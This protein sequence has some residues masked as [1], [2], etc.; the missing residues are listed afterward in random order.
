MLRNDLGL[1][2]LNIYRPDRYRRYMP[3]EQFPDTAPGQAIDNFVMA[4]VNHYRRVAMSPQCAYDS[5]GQIF[6]LKTNM[7]FDIFFRHAGIL[8]QSG[9]CGKHLVGCLYIALVAHISAPEFMFRP[10][11]FGCGCPA[12]MFP[13]GGR[14]AAHQCDIT[15]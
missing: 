1:P 12:A 2:V 5:F 6:T 8:K 14:T 10:G 15:I 4:S 3:C 11:S 13:V 9:G 7:R